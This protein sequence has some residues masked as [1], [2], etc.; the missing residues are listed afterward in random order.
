MTVDLKAHAEAIITACGNYF[1]YGETNSDRA[2]PP[3][4]TNYGPR[5]RLTARVDDGMINKAQGYA[6]LS[7]DGRK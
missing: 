4:R 3:R 5:R 7:V 6:V 1:A 2:A